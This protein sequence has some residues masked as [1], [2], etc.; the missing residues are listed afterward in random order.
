MPV[1]PLRRHLR[2]MIAALAA[3]VIAISPLAVAG[4]AAALT[5]GSIS[6]VLTSNGAPLTQLSVLAISAE[7][8]GYSGDLTGNPGEYVIS[9]LPVG[10]YRVQFQSSE[11]VVSE[12]WAD[13]PTQESATPIAVG[14]NESITGI[15]ADL[16]SGAA[17]NGTV[18][19]ESGT[20]VESA[21]VQVVSADDPSRLLGAGSTDPSG[22]WRIAGLPGGNVKIQ[23]QAP[24]GFLSEWF[25]NAVDF[26]SATPFEAV[27][28]AENDLGATALG[29][30]GA[31]EGVVTDTDT[32]LPVPNASVLATPTGQD[33]N[34]VHSVVTDEVG[35]YRIDSL[36]AGSYDVRITSSDGSYLEEWHAD[37]LLRDG[38]QPVTVVA[39][40][41][42]SVI[43]FALTPAGVIEGRVS[44]AVS[45]APV[46]DA[47]VFVKRVG[48]EF[49][50]T[51]A[52]T[53]GSGSYRASGLPEG[54]YVVQ[55][56]TYGTAYLDTW[57][58][59]AEVEV[60]AQ[61]VAV[62]RG[63]TVS[64]IDVRLPRGGSFSGLVTDSAGVP[65][66][67]VSVSASNYE[68]GVYRNAVTAA[69]GSYQVGGL[70]SGP[71]SVQ[72]SGQ[73]AGYLSLA[74]DEPVDV[75]VG[76]DTSGIDATLGLGSTIAGTVVDVDGAPIES[77]F[78]CAEAVSGGAFGGC[79]STDA[80][81]AYS[82]RGLAD[83][84]W[85]VRF[86]G[87][88]SRFISEYWEDA[89]TRDTAAPV[90]VSSGAIVGGVNAV[91]ALGGSITGVVT[92]D[93]AP[94]VGLSGVSV[95]AQSDDGAVFASAMT[96][97]DGSY[98][99]DGLP[100][101][102][103]SVQFTTDFDSGY[104]GEFWNDVATRSEATP[105]AVTA[106]SAV[107]G[108]S[109]S[110]A[111]GATISG[112][113]TDADGVPVS[114]VSVYAAPEGLL[115]GFNGGYAMTD[116]AGAYTLRGLRAG[117]YKLLFA[118]ESADAAVRSEWWD[119]AQLTSAATDIQVASGE[120]LTGV[121]AR[122]GPIG[123]PVRASAPVVSDRGAGTGAIWT[124]PTSAEPI[125]GYGVTI[126]FGGAGDGAFFTALDP[127]EF[128][129]DFPY[130]SA[131]ISV[132]AL[133]A[134][135]FGALG[136][137]I[138]VGS[139]G[140][141]PGPQVVATEVTSSA[142]ELAFEIGEPTG[143]PVTS[144]RI[145]GRSSDLSSLG[146]FGF[147]E[148]SPENV[149][150]FQMTGLQPATTY[151]FFV[152]GGEYGDETDFTAYTVTTSAVDVAPFIAAPNPIVSG[153][154]RVG[155]TLTAT[156]GSWSPIPGAFAYQWTRNGTPITGATAAS[157]TP[158]PADVAATIRVRVTGSR[159]GFLTTTRT[160]APLT[161]Q[162]GVLTTSKP[163]VSGLP[164]IGAQLTAVPG[165]WGPS[166]V[167]LDFQWLR[168]GAP[169][170]GATKAT[171][172]PV[173]VDEGQ[174]LSV[175]VT[176]T[177]SGFA[178]AS[179]TSAGLPR[180]STTPGVDPIRLAGQ[181]RYATAA[182]IAAT[183]P[184]G[185]DVVYVATGADYP[186]ALG[187]AAAAARAGG[188]LLLVERGRIPDPIARQ[189]TRLKPRLIVA[190]GGTGVI[191]SSVVS[192]LREFAGSGGVRR[193]AGKDRY[194]TSRIVAERAF[195][196]EGARLAYVAT[197]SNFPD[198]LAASAAAGAVSGPVILVNGRANSVDAPTRA[199]IADLGLSKLVV[200]G[201]TGVVSSSLER[202]LRSL[203]G[204]AS[205]VRRSGA[206]RYSTAVAINSAAFSTAE[207]VFLATGLSFPDALAGAAMA[208]AAPGPLFVVPGTCVPRAVLD[209]IARLG[210][211]EIVLLGGSGV[212]GSGVRDLLACS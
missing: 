32:G 12:W 190:V 197:G 2:G 21:W 125:L 147:V 101:G 161:V 183:F 200:A 46:A 122:L 145:L 43:D 33:L 94:T 188:P 40:G 202:S 97:D 11:N 127:R 180:V 198:A 8:L 76:Q 23:I 194:E 184:A 96:S 138:I 207:S 141:R 67:G 52:W 7:G 93:D 111:V 178:S 77:I 129:T 88:G 134:S 156:T 55:V 208:G 62:G 182:A 112:T 68:L 81:G 118:S 120:S 115:S 191:S 1:S 132:R 10:E 39:G 30:S 105:V 38:A 195:G 186:D 131:V 146:L 73:E 114:R 72:F 22:A 159:E 204:V 143:S 17:L 59:G 51:S 102:S 60:D 170:A 110:L 211:S 140:G 28:G 163:T 196:A 162:A 87:S 137:G 181:D 34:F 70:P 201:G 61:L 16:S 176:G 203:D 165:Q 104:V 149:G 135:G 187:A 92:A 144:W 175:R 25:E 139:Q 85:L 158:K 3:V 117:S 79:A 74:R 192:Q 37:S 123:T 44:D 9:G 58:D 109:P 121:D 136:S 124:Q 126:D 42:A 179:V 6:G 24:V 169:I 15:D 57:F 54:D 185:V 53:D 100:T 171:Y 19:S 49:P 160:S 63:A 99:L 206:D 173:E 199:L 152:K 130:S 82:V 89:S 31:I 212:L 75:V 189:L 119:D 210:A 45:D 47:V 14:E 18:E 148:Q 64:G 26:E 193:D 154:P 41:A 50:F 103:F 142:V 167:T 133:T 83:G 153:A 71:Y 90:A 177:K 168:G 106:P 86:D 65:I 80:A 35:V 174:V 69:D 5:G 107:G 157:Y 66:A 13:Q 91:L 155:S 113:I 56:N 166:P 84:E 48:D 205:V 98:R 78:V 36:P 209:Q 151:T 27:A 172:V 4:P 29:A 128:L 95:S 164:Q 108:I 20:A 116:E 150:T